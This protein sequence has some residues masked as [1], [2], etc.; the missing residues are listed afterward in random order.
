MCNSQ[1]GQALIMMAL[2]MMVNKVYGSSVNSV[3]SRGR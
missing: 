1:D 2:I 3:D